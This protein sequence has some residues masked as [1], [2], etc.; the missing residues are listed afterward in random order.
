MA[1]R[2][3]GFDVTA[4]SVGAEGDAFVISG[5][6]PGSTIGPTTVR[7]LSGN[8]GHAIWTTSL[9]PE[10]FTYVQIRDARL[11]GF[12]RFIVLIS[13]T[14]RDGEDRFWELRSLDAASEISRGER[15][16]RDPPMRSRSILIARSH[17]PCRPV[18]RS[19][20]SGRSARRRSRRTLALVAID[21]AAG[22]R[23]L[24]LRT[25][26]ARIGFQRREGGRG[27]ARRIAGRHRTDRRQEVRHGHVRVCRLR[28]SDG[29]PLWETTVNAS[30]SYALGE[31]VAV[32]VDR[33]GN[34]GVV[35][36]L[37]NPSFD[38]RAAIAKLLPNGVSF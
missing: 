36:T 9:L 5:D 3:T 25:A 19:M 21:A 1:R 26:E 17:S 30:P 7:R 23:A 22:G 24:A 28:P 33:N 13:S 32:G 31:G 27:R 15:R 6:N 35:G 11:D 2:G 10:G 18:G 20:R 16:S 29:Q 4:L 12:G 38:V 34:V 8:D 37:G 14:T